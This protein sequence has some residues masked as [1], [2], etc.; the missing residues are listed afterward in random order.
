VKPPLTYYGGKQQ[1][2]KTIMSLIPKH[3]LYCEPFFGGGAIF[4]AKNPSSLE[5]IND[6]NGELINFY[7]VL[8]TQFQSLQKEIESTLHSRQEHYRASVITLHPS[9]FTPIQRAWAVWVLANQSFASKLNGSWGYDRVTNK[10][11]K[12]LDAKRNAFKSELVKRLSLVQLES[13]DALQ[14]ILSRDSKNAFFYCDPPYFNS[15][16]GHY[17]HY[18][19]ADFQKLLDVLSNLKGKF[20]LSSYESD[21]LRTYTNRCKWFTQKVD[22]PLAVSSH[23]HVKNKRKYEIL[24]ANYPI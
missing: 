2:S 7:K 16:K 24:T 21:L 20:L 9:L 1:L 12:Q 17:K 5:V 22:M 4:F 10:S 18:S 8:K 13:A 23:P 11:A 6:T 3:D 15:H 19:Q 14:V